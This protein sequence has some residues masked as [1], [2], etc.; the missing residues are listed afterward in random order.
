[1]N[2]DSALREL[3]A[4]SIWLDDT[5]FGYV[6]EE[7]DERYVMGDF[8]EAVPVEWYQGEHYFMGEH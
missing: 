5:R 7:Q 3:V 4:Q 6:H 1:M 8:G 2:A